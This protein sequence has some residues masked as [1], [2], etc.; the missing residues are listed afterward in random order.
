[1]IVLDATISNVSYARDFGRIEAKVTL[2]VKT[3]HQPVRAIGIR[4]NVLARGDAPLRTR[5][6]EDAAI[7]VRNRLAVQSQRTAEVA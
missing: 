7:L 4:T 3:A 6:L 5:L 1:M 2:I